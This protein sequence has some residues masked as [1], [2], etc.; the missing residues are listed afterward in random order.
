MKRAFQELRQAL[1]EAPALALPDPSK[2]FQ[3]FVDEK[4]EIRKGVLMQPW[5]PWRRPV[6]YLSKRLD[7]VAVGWPPCLQIIAAT[8]LLVHDADKLTYAQRLLVYTPHTIKGILKQPPGKWI[9]NARLT[10]YQA[11]LDTPRIH[12]QMPCFLNLATLLPNPEEDSPLHDCSEILA[13]TTA[14]RK[15]L[16][17][18]PLNNS[19]LIWFTD[20][21]SFIKDGQKKAGAAI[22]DDS[23]KI[24]WAEALPPGTSAQKAE[25]IALIQALGR[26]KGNESLFIPTVGM[27]SAPYTSRAQYIKS[28]DF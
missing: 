9:S 7:P 12:F 1:L 27:H 15:D 25:L 6:A 23:G 5:G 2:P 16:T 8:A 11:L 14:I 13:E 17:D 26:A 20:G 18:V 24:I 19:E 28:G 4:W 10:H 3:L 22:V 21:S